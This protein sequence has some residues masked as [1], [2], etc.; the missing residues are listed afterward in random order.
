MAFGLRNA[1]VDIAVRDGLCRAARGLRL[2]PVARRR[3]GLLIEVCEVGLADQ[4]A[5]VVLREG[6]DLVE[7]RLVEDQIVE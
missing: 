4:H 1:R 6:F 7:G 5:E 2:R 3:R